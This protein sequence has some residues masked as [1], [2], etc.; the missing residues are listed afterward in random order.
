MNVYQYVNG[1]PLGFLDPSG[2]V[3]CRIDDFDRIDCM[4]DYQDDLW[5]CG[6]DFTYCIAKDWLKCEVACLFVCLP[7]W[8][9]GPKGYAICMA[10]CTGACTLK[11]IGHDWPICEQS[12][13]A[14]EA[15]ADRDYQK[16]LGT[17]ISD[18]SR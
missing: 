11:T 6:T 8:W 17:I 1:M 9:W 3:L 13:I 4:E 2:L 18:T 16:L 5:K 10:A 7:S 14:C 15:K 12:K